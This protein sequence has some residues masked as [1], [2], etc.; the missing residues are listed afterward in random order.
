MGTW[1]FRSK[2]PRRSNQLT[3]EQSKFTP[4]A[5]R[6]RVRA[7]DCN[8]DV[9]PWFLHCPANARRPVRNLFHVF[10]DNI[11]SSLTERLPIEQRPTIPKQSLDPNCRLW[12]VDRRGDSLENPG[13]YRTTV[14]AAEGPQGQLA[15]GRV[16]NCQ[17]RQEPAQTVKPLIPC[18][19]C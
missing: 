14:G 2:S 8:G 4:D 18:A 15:S 6:L 10:P 19:R 12:G 9:G 11:S 3:K 1:S 17:T 5:E 16:T 7:V 13:W